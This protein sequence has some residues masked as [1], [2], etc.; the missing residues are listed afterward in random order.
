LINRFV[1]HRSRT[2]ALVSRMKSTVATPCT[3]AY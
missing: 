3:P 2:A 1:F